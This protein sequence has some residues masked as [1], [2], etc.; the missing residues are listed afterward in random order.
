MPM[1]LHELQQSF[2][3]AFNDDD[4]TDFVDEVV[5][6]GTLSAEQRLQVYKDSIT[7]SLVNTLAEIYPVCLRLVGEEY[8]H[9]MANIY[10]KQTPSYSPDLGDYGETFAKFIDHFPPAQQ[11]PYFG[12]TARLEWAWHRAFNGP[13]AQELDFT[14]LS[15]VHEKIGEAISFT[16]PENSTLLAS[17]FPIDRI[18]ETNQPNFTGDDIV[19]LDNN[20]VRLI[21][22]RKQLNVLI[23]QLTRDEWFLLTMFA[24]GLNLT[25]VFQHAAQHKIKL[26][27]VAQLPRLAERGWLSGFINTKEL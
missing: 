25:E 23:E 26:D 10:V 2:L 9:A 20:A 22:W 14:A 24:N 7:A 17:D 27:I 16:L 8:F 1:P 18:W 11:L 19:N 21:V 6:A 4:N 12:D 13:D 3:N 15:A 5:N